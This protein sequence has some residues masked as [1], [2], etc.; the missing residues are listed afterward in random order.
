MES[1]IYLIVVVLLLVLIVAPIII[2]VSQS[3]ANGKLDAL[4]RQMNDLNQKIMILM[5]RSVDTVRVRHEVKTEAVEEVQDIEPERNEILEHIVSTFEEEF[6]EI[7]EKEIKEKLIEEQIVGDLLAEDMEVPSEEILQEELASS[8]MAAELQAEEESIVGNVQ[9]ESSFVRNNVPQEPEKNLLERILGDNWLSKVGIVTLVLGI[10]FFV[11][12][13]IDQDW[14][15]EIGRVG[16]GLLTGGIIV[17]VAHRLKEKYHVFS[18]ILVGGGISVFYI[19]ITL[20]FREYAIFNQTIAFILLIIV[21]VFSVVLSL[22]YNRQELAIFSLVGGYLSPL[23]VS[24]GTGNYIV[25][26]SLLLIL[27]SG[28][29]IISLK[30]NWRLIGIIAYGLSLI[31]F[32]AWLLVKF[33]YEYIGATV[34]ASLFFVQ[35]YA[36]AIIEHYSVQ[37][38][39]TIYQALL[40]L[41][42]NLSVF[43]ACMYIFSGHDYNFRGLITLAIAVVNAV[44]MIALFRETRIDK[45]MIYLIIAIVMSLVSLAIPIQMR[46]HVITMFWAAESVLLLWLW[47]RSRINVFWLGFLAISLLTIISYIIDVEHNYYYGAELSILIN[48]IC[49]TGLVVIAAF[50]INLYLLAQENKTGEGRPKYLQVKDVFNVLKFGLIVLCFFVPYLE[51]NH[52]LEVRTDLDMYVSS[53][54][55]VSLGTY[56]SLFFASLAVIFRNKIDRVKYYVFFVVVVLYTVIYTALTADLRKDI[57]MYEYYSSGYFLIH[58]LSLLAVGYLIYV[59][60]KN[61]KIVVQKQFKLICWL[62][63]ILSTAILSFELDH[64]IIWLFSN[65]DTYYSLLYDVHT[66]GYPILWGII[67]MVLMVWG[68]QKKEVVLRKI[69]LISFG[70][71]ILKFY[72]YDV[73]YMSQTG[74]IVSFVLL[75]VILLVVSFLQ[76]KIKVLVK[77]DTE[78]PSL[79]SNG[80]N[81]EEI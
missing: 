61:I 68:L 24:T 81:D 38:R 77:D 18:S 73:W 79:D 70:F 53:F 35:F 50:A 15:N 58:Y 3:T 55:Y 44:V 62:L 9:P 49:I 80:T 69:S 42:N 31:F 4:Q 57:Y 33:E 52:Q 13:A 54:R 34:F 51:L 59:L 48:S 26:F 7:E 74:R 72:A 65:P 75:G 29:L 14:I 27:N 12:Y 2:I 64:T 8:Y 60:V 6:P 43:L 5:E 47:R 36:L 10:G 63:V 22:L 56:A 46:G 21:T 76:Q 67:A 71:I 16:I 40:I 1:L 11:K 28:M 66:F 19:T 78:T 39:M 30:K 25:L 20:A 17:G 37:K 45:N 41:T 32:W 23:M